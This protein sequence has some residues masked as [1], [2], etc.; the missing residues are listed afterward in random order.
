MKRNILS[1]ILLSSM[2]FSCSGNSNPLT[3]NDVGEEENVRNY[4]EIF[5]RSFYDSNDDGIGD[6]NGVTAKLDYIKDLG[7]NGIWLMP[8]NKAYSYHKYDIIDYYDIDPEYGTLDDLD[9]LLSEAKKRDI[10]V[11]LDLVVNHTSNMH[12]WFIESINANLNNTDSKYKDYYNFSTTAKSKYTKYGSI[13]YESQFVSSMPD[14]NLD[15]D[16]VKNEI[17]NIIKFYLDKGVSGF[18]LDTVINYYTGNQDKNAEFIKFIVDYAKSLNPNCYIVAEAWTNNAEIKKYYETGIDS[19][20]AFGTGSEL[21]VSMT[22]SSWSTYYSLLNSVKNIAGE[23]IPA[24]F[25]GNHDVGRAAGILGR[26]IKKVKFGYG[27]LGMLNGNV[28]AYYGDEIGMIASGISM[29]DY[30]DKSYRIAIPWDKDKKDGFC[31]NPEG[32]SNPEYIYPSVEEQL[33]DSNSILNYYK[34]VNYLRNNYPVISK[35]DI[36]LI[37]ST[38]NSGIIKKKY[39]D[40]EIYIAINFLDEPTTIELDGDFEIVNSLKSDESSKI[41]IKENKLNICDY[42]IA[43][44]KRK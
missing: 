30:L 5:V 38:K 4:Y 1:L 42:S 32:V 10:K 35:G 9:Y 2:L 22:M 3:F 21:G 41:Y 34:K 13:Y 37:S 39:N 33:K 6:L 28:F 7:Y 19:C 29:G 24:P 14:L 40:E 8:I 17:K 20:F 43:L 16:N 23:Y 26:K 31:L 25:I 15:S 36:E 44:L 12:P 27:L 18:R 11:I